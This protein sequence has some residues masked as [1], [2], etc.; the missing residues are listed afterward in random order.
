MEKNTNPWTNLLTYENGTLD[1][2]WDCMEDFLVN[3]PDVVADPEDPF[4]LFQGCDTNADIEAR[5]LHLRTQHSLSNYNTEEGDEAPEEAR[6]REIFKSYI[7]C[8]NAIIFSAASSV[9]NTEKITNEEVDRELVDMIKPKGMKITDGYRSTSG[10]ASILRIEK[11]TTYYQSSFWT[12]F[13]N[14]NVAS[15]DDKTTEELTEYVLAPGYAMFSFLSLVCDIPDSMSRSDITAIKIIWAPE[16]NSRLQLHGQYSILVNYIQHNPEDYIRISY[17]RIAEL[18]N[19]FYHY[20]QL[21]VLGKPFGTNGRSSVNWTN[22]DV[23][24]TLQYLRKGNSLKGVRDPAIAKHDYKKNYS[25]GKK[26]Y[27]KSKKWN[28]Y[29]KK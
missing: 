6:K 15:A 23:F 8:V 17:T 25:N 28:H 3:G 13:Y 12:G 22:N 27:K 11:N 4:D 18:W 19:S 16:L 1:I 14:T 9:Y 10:N 26:M 20:Y 2:N 21:K 5:L 24:K 29:K 7:L